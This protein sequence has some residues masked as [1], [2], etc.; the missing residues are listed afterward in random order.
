[1]LNASID[2]VALEAAHMQLTRCI[3]SLFSGIVIVAIFNE[4]I[5]IAWLLCGVALEVWCSFIRSRLA[6]GGTPLWRLQYV[7]MATCLSALWTTLPVLL[8]LSHH[9]AFQITAIMMLFSQL[10][11]AQTLVSRSVA[12]LTVSAGLPAAALVV[13]SLRYG[14][15]SGLELLAIVAGIFL[16]LGYLT[17]AFL[18]NAA[19]ATRLDRAQTELEQIAYFDVLTSL[20]NRR[21]F[22][23]DLRQL[24]ETSERR[25]LQFT[26]L[27]LDL[28]DF[29]WINDSFGHAAGDICLREVG[30]RLCRAVRKGDYL[31]R[32]G[33]DEFAVLL[34]DTYESTAIE[35]IC[36]RIKDSFA[37]EVQL[38]GARVVSSSSI[39][40]ALYPGDGDNEISLLRAADLAM[41][42]A[43]R[44]RHA[45]SNHPATVARSTYRY[46]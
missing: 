24:I 4:A 29:K 17:V 15:F 45:H 2:K 20:A 36:E 39:G 37:E 35:H 5:G 3:V 32:I 10:L 22:F 40:I 21:L 38:T 34:P 8:W 6:Q 7:I 44:I 1:M 33:G 30:I 18:S 16:S 41:Y 19:R 23:N 46:A 31:A 43:K 14:N 13:L 27:L 25:Q 9:V 28:D 26:L 11:S 12:L 42:E